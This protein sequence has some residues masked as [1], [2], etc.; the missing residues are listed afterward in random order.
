MGIKTKLSI[1]AAF[2]LAA[3]GGAW[4]GARNYLNSETYLAEK[5]ERTVKRA[6]GQ[7]MA[8]PGSTPVAKGVAQFFDNTMLVT[9]DGDTVTRAPIY[10]KLKALAAEM[11]E[12]DSYNEFETSVTRHWVGRNASTPGIV[13]ERNPDMKL[14]TMPDHL[15]VSTLRD[16]ERWTRDFINHVQAHGRYNTV[17]AKPEHADAKKFISDFAVQS[18]NVLI[19]SGQ[20]PAPAGGVKATYA[21]NPLT[22]PLADLMPGADGQQSR[23]FLVYASVANALSRLENDG[24]FIST[25]SEIGRLMQQGTT[26]ARRDGCRLVER[27]SAS[28]SNITASDQYGEAIARVKREMKDVDVKKTITDLGK[29]LKTA[30]QALSRQSGVCGP[31]YRP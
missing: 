22:A 4:L 8:D 5:H 23:P 9:R 17:I 13:G 30:G 15:R 25:A 21:A 31:G 29:T 14:G 24:S 7:D 16:I 12:S 26:D 1:A 3:S 10:D 2:A 19:V 6:L 28:I 18:R 27:W 11:G 20:T